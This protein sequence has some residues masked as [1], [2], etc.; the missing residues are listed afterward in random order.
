MISSLQISGS[1]LT[2]ERLRLDV[3]SQ[4]IANAQTTRGADGRAY[5]RREVVFEE[6]PFALIH[7]G[8]PAEG[9]VAAT[10]VLTSENPT[11]RVFH[12]GHPDADRRGYVELPNVNLVEEMVDLIAAT[13]A[14]EA[15]IAAVQATKTMVSRAL[16]LGRG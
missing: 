14:Y 2:A 5:R 16:E 3:I 9:G 12:P 15:N 4:N 13:R 11:I 7:G 10:E 1:A 6:V 8:V